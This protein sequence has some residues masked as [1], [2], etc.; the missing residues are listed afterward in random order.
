MYH[1]TRPSNK[2]RGRSAVLIKDSTKHTEDMKIEM[3]Q[4]STVCMQTKHMKA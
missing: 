2:T 3:M 4:V 1:S